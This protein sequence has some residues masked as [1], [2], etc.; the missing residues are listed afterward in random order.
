MCSTL[1]VAA[2]PEVSLAVLQTA[3]RE[4]DAALSTLAARRAVLLDALD[5]CGAGLV[6][7]GQGSSMPL[8]PWLRDATGMAFVSAR[9]AVELARGLAALPSVRDASVA[10]ELRMDRAEVLA[11]DLAPHIPVEPLAA[12]EQPLLEAARLCEPTALRSRIRSWVADNLPET[13]TDD[14]ASVKP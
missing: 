11:L 3:V 10:G 14:E 6:P 1:D 5:S 9:R 13:F 4:N 2:A 7:D 8:V 12:A